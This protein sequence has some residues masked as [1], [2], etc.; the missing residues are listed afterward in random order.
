MSTY[1]YLKTPQTRQSLEDMGVQFHDGMIERRDGTKTPH[2]WIVEG[3][4]DT[5]FT[6][7]LHP[8][9]DEQNM[10]SGWTRYAG[11]SSSNL[12]DIL[13]FNDVIFCSEY[14]CEIDVDLETISEVFGI[15]TNDENLVE[16]VWDY[17]IGEVPSIDLYFSD[18]KKQF[19]IDFLEEDKETW[20]NYLEEYLA[21]QE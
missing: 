1:Y 14:D 2:T 8:Y 20:E 5:G 6:N 18:D 17:L 4:E 13:D 12:I 10:V 3:N 21:E 11:N 9:I 15:D 19:L 7:Y 16:V